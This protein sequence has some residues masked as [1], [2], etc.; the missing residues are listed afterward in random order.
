MISKTLPSLNYYILNLTAALSSQDHIDYKHFMSKLSQFESYIITFENLLHEW[1]TV[2]EG[3]PD[4]IDALLENLTEF[5]YGYQI[6]IGL[7]RKLLIDYK[8]LKMDIDINN[9]MT[10]L[11]KFPVLDKEQNDYIK[12]FEI[13]T[14]NKISELIFN[15][16][17]DKTGSTDYK[18]HIKDQAGQAHIT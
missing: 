18:T 6:K 9:L 17:K 16:L 13:V 5:L 8:Y 14:S 11:V 7:L 15:I 2:G 4:I 10:N 3:Y 1:T 12:H